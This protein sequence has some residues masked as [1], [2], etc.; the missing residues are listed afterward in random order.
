MLLKYPK[1]TSTRIG[2]TGKI[3]QALFMKEQLS[4]LKCSS[5]HVAC[6]M[7]HVAV[8]KVNLKTVADVYSQLIL[9]STRKLKCLNIACPDAPI[10]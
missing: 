1:H 7:L 2:F 10:Y 3:C 5:F 4:T 8:N 9:S 6:C